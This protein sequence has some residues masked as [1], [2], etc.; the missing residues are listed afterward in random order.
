MRFAGRLGG[1][2]R[3]R[4]ASDRLRDAAE[5][6]PR[7]GCVALL[8]NAASGALV[9]VK[10]VPVEPAPLVQVPA[11]AERLALVQDVEEAG[12][13][14]VDVVAG[15][16]DVRPLWRRRGIEDGSEPDRRLPDPTH[17]IVV[18]E[19]QAPR[20][21]DQ[22]PGAYVAVDQPV[23]VEHAEPSQA[24]RSQRT[25]SWA[26]DDSCRSSASSESTPANSARGEPSTQVISATSSLSRHAAGRLEDRRQPGV[27]AQ[28][29]SGE[30]IGPED[31]LADRAVVGRLGD[32]GA[33][34]FP[35]ARSRS[36]TLKVVPTPPLPRWLRIR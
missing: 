27:P 19:N 33:E 26:A 7:S 13:Q 16:G 18:G 3:R 28:V 35:V 8:K 11:V 22:I 21:D 24:E 17:E 34:I 29:G 1:A 4:Q 15:G 14:G 36:T 30:A 32:V 31:A 5:A 12:R 9:A 10:P 20:R 2:I 23:A 6:A 25:A